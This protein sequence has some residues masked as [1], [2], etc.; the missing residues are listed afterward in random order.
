MGTKDSNSYRQYAQFIFFS[1]NKIAIALKTTP[2]WNLCGVLS[3]YLIYSIHPRQCQFF[4]CNLWAHVKS[5][6]SAHAH[7]RPPLR[8][9]LKYKPYLF[10]RFQLCHMHLPWSKLVYFFVV[11]VSSEW[12]DIFAICLT[13]HRNP[14]LPCS[15]ITYQYIATISMWL[16]Y[17]S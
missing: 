17:T 16:H 14:S 7:V 5:M 12:Y 3:E 9:Y 1:Q 6:L 10:M 4:Y 13:L 2:P 15:Y 8:N 11:R